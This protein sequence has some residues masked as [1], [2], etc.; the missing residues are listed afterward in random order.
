MEV[1]ALLMTAAFFDLWR[2]YLRQYI[3]VIVFRFTTAIL[4]VKQQRKNF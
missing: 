3:R 2:N 4:N 1:S